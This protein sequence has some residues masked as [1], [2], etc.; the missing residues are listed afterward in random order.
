MFDFLTETG[1][2][3]NARVKINDETKTVADKALWTEESLPA[4][5][6][7]AGVIACDRVFG[8]DGKDITPAGLLD[9]F[10]TDPLYLQIGGKATVGRGQVR[11]VFTRTEGGAK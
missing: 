4:E 1:T 2:E 11:C 10:A 8:R 3:V 7:L 5:T 9:K 6:I